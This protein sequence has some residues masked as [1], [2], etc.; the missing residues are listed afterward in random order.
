MQK[1]EWVQARNKKAASG[2]NSSAQNYGNVASKSAPDGNTLSADVNQT[3]Y[4]RRL[5]K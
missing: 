4:T 1:V 3:K 5:I 2:I